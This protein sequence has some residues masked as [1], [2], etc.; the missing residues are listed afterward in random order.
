MAQGLAGAVF[1]SEKLPGPTRGNQK[2]TAERSV[3]GLKPQF[4]THCAVDKADWPQL[5][6]WRR[7]QEVC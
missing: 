1:P 3:P 2:L 6:L 5:F 7:G 4:N